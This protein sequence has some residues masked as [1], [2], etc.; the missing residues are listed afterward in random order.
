[1]ITPGRLPLKGTIVIDQP[2]AETGQCGEA[3]FL[4]P[5]TCVLTPNGRSIACQ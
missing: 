2:T 1:L 5:P 3:V 4:G